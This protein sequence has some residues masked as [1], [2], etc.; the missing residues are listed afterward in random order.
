MNWNKQIQSMFTNIDH[1]NN[2]NTNIYNGYHTKSIQDLFNRHQSKNIIQ[3]W[4]SDKKTPKRDWLLLH[5]VDFNTI[6]KC[7]KLYPSEK[8]KSFS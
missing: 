6:K 7:L 3:W 5:L 8:T 1:E 2:I 4:Q